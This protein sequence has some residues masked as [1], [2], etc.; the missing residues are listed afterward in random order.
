MAEKAVRCKSIND[1][2]YAVEKLLLAAHREG[3][4]LSELEELILDQHYRA[5]ADL[6]GIR[7]EGLLGTP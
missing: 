1:H 6:A 5:I 2:G 4:T 7:Y 3:R